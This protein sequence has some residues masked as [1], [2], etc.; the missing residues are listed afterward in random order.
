MNKFFEEILIKIRLYKY[1]NNC[2]KL[3]KIDALKCKYCK[4]YIKE[5]PVIDEITSPN[6]ENESDEILCPY[7]SEKIKRTAKKCKHCGEWLDKKEKVLHFDFSSIKSFFLF[8]LMCII[9][10]GIYTLFNNGITFTKATCD[11]EKTLSLLEELFTEEGW[12]KGFRDSIELY[13]PGGYNLKSVK[14]QDI[15]TL[16]ENKDKTSCKCKANAIAKWSLNVGKDTENFALKC[17]LSY[18]VKIEDNQLKVD[19]YLP[20]TSNFYAVCSGYNDN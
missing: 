2:G 16:S 13:I 8:I 11:S 20:N 4:S 14:F 5:K 12:L 18:Y 9:F 19:A 3:I 15:Q 7:C 6:I 17:K 10:A 1:C